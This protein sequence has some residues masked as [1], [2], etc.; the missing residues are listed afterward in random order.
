MPTKQQ[1]VNPNPN[2]N[3]KPYLVSNLEK[4][5]KN[6]EKVSSKRDSKFEPTAS[7]Q[8][9]SRYAHSQ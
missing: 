3:P 5:R 7:R 2:P 6:V 1:V 8:A 4:L 9:R